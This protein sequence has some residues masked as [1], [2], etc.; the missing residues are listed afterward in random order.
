[1]A[2]APG[3]KV[4][5]KSAANLARWDA[6]CMNE[7]RNV[8][9]KLPALNTE[10]KLTIIDVGAN[11]GTFAELMLKESPY[12]FERILLFEPVP[13]YARWAAF[14]FSCLVSDPS[15]DVMEY[16]LSDKKGIGK[17]AINNRD[18]NFGWNTMVKDWQ[19][20]CSDTILDVPMV[21]F[22]EIYQTL[23]FK[24]GIDLIKIDV[25]GYEVKVL[26]GMKETLMSLEEKPPL[27]VEIADGS[28]HHDMENLQI[29]LN[30]LK[31][32]GY[33]FDDVEKWPKGT[34]DL[35]ISQ[36]GSVFQG[37]IEVEEKEP[38]SKKNDLPNSVEEV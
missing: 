12:K 17:I 3:W 5:H 14:K 7:L 36:P 29:T 4:T 21:P 28:K 30:N 32:L 26:N 13:L 11:T 34:F 20:D 18:S 23:Q 24:N 37:V 33:I 8:K 15:I 9:D 38:I 27:V 31:D 19:K 35:V 6:V 10:K 16:S 2:I 25:E 22:D 1:M